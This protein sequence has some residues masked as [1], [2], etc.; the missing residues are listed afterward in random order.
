MQR[1]AVPYIIP[2]DPIVISKRSNPEKELQLFIKEIEETIEE[3]KMNS[4]LE[5]LIAYVV[6]FDCL[7]QINRDYPSAAEVMRSEMYISTLLISGV[8]NKRYHK[9]NPEKFFLQK[10]SFEEWIILRITLRESNF[11]YRGAMDIITEKIKETIEEDKTIKSFYR[12]FVRNCYFA[13]NRNN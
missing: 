2:I 10:L 11:S 6:A 7:M 4:P 1:H 13:G 12:L 5:K 3:L 9:I 8:Y